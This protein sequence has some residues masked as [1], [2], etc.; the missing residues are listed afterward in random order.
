MFLQ[1]RNLDAQ[2]CFT[3]LCKILLVFSLLVY[4]E[5]III[6]VFK[7]DVNTEIEI[8]KRSIDDI[9]MIEE[10]HIEKDKELLE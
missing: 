7:L 9:G 10:L 6:H 4:N 3:F 1:L 2:F 8:K 5:V